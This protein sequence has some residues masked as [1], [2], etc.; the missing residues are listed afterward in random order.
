MQNTTQ[1][2]YFV[3]NR[4][5]GKYFVYHKDLAENLLLTATRNIN[6]KSLSASQLTDIWHRDCEAIFWEQIQDLAA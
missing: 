3:L 1:N 2:T 6:H 4:A 5:L